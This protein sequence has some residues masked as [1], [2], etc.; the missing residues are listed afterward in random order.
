[1]QSPK[2]SFVKLHVVLTTGAASA[3]SNMSCIYQNAASISFGPQDIAMRTE[4]CFEDKMK[5]S[6]LLLLVLKT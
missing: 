2:P 5:M 6:P 3:F 1:M 4:K